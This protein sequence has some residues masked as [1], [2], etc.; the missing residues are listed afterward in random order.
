MTHFED[1]LSGRSLTVGRIGGSTI[2]SY[3]EEV[4]FSHVIR[5]FVYRRRHQ[6]VW[7]LEG[8]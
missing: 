5:V 1:I 8:P 4:S 3:H 6:M 2:I 7:Y